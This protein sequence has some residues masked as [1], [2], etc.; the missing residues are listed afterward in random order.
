MD[1]TSYLVSSAMAMSQA[2]T[3]QAA[4]V[5]LMKK[6]MDVQAEQSQALFQMMSPPPAFGHQLNLYA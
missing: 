2:K 6:T 4:G 5:S 3:E 1:I